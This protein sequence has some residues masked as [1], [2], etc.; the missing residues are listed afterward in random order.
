MFLSYKCFIYCW[1][2]CYWKKCGWGQIIN[3]KRQVF[4][5]QSYSTVYLRKKKMA[6]N[7]AECS[8]QVPFWAGLFYLYHFVIARSIKTKLRPAL[9][10]S[11]LPFSLSAFLDRWR[12]GKGQDLGAF[13]SC[14]LSMASF[15]LQ[16]ALPAATW[17]CSHYY[18]AWHTCGL[19]PGKEQN[20]EEGRLLFYEETADLQSFIPPKPYHCEDE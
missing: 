12:E 5:N 2:S 20:P 16:T 3:L 11:S 17:A 14:R 6:E 13:P 18:S 8:N 15:V 10:H 1:N 4:Y 9:L 7:S 19:S